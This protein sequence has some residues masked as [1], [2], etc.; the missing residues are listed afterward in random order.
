[1]ETAAG[2]GLIFVGVRGPVRDLSVATI[3]LQELGCLG[4]VGVVRRVQ[5]HPQGFDDR[6]FC[7]QRFC[8]TCERN[9]LQKS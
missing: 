7:E 4:L 6:G 1:M 8:M 5:L 9:R 2:A 3:T